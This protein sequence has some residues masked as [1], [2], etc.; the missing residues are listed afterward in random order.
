MLPEMHDLMNHIIREKQFSY[1]IKLPS[2]W[3]V[4]SMTFKHAADRLF[5]I[6]LQGKERLLQRYAKTLTGDRESKVKRK[7]DDEELE[8][9]NDMELISIYYLLAGYALEN[10]LKA[11]VL[12]IDSEIATNYPKKIK[13]HDL[14]KLSQWGKLDLNPNEMEILDRLKD[15]IIWMAKYPIPTKL[16]DMYPKPKADGTWEEGNFSLRGKELKNQID[17]IYEKAYSYLK[18][19]RALERD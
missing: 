2:G 12:T 10:M 9:M 6:H 7:I 18:D 8:E 11:I 14:G 16:E 3:V 17:G 19:I 5:E 15:H 13:T 4:K 1:N